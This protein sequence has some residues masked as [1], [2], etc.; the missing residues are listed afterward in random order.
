MPKLGRWHFVG[1]SLIR[2][3]GFFIA[4]DIVQTYVYLHP[5][6]PDQSLNQL[7]LLQQYLLTCSWVFS[8]IFSTSMMYYLFAA[9][10]VALGLSSWHLWPPVYGRFREAY[11][12]RRLWR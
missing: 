10:T 4:L 8:G 7:P 5:R 1:W 3:F 12:V 6:L 9:G 2:A 11:S